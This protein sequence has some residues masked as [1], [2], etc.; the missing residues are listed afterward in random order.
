MVSDHFA[1]CNPFHYLSSPIAC[2]VWKL[3]WEMRW[4]SQIAFIACSVAVGENRFPD[5]GVA[6]PHGRFSSLNRPVRASMHK[7]PACLKP[8]SPKH[9]D[10]MKRARR[11]LPPQRSHSVR[12]PLDKIRLA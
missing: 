2:G 5:D 9:T 4:R 3:A 12:P 1:F 10:P 6:V 11:A 8:T 7:E